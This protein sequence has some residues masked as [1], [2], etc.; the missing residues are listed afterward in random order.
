MQQRLGRLERRPLT[1][2]THWDLE[3]QRGN[4][5]LTLAKP[6]N[7]QLSELTPC[8]DRDVWRERVVCHTRTRARV[9]VK[10]LGEHLGPI[11]VNCQAPSP[12]P[13]RESKWV[14]MRL[15]YIHT[16]EY[17]PRPYGCGS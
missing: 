13:Q 4:T 10:V 6:N 2:S 9:D 5:E 11:S 3:S 8:P 7:F 17:P 1:Q 14:K 12:P 16:E 15:C